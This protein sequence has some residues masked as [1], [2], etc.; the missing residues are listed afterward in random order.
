VTTAGALWPSNS[1][2]RGSSSPNDGGF[3][4]SASPGDAFLKE[5]TPELVESGDLTILKP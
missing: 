5:I 3:K 1:P 4:K 2:G